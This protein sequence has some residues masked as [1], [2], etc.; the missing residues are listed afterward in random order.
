[1]ETSHFATFEESYD[2]LAAYSTQNGFGR[3]VEA[4]LVALLD[5]DG[6]FVVELVGFNERQKIVP[7]V[8][9]PLLQNL[10]VEAAGWAGDEDVEGAPVRTQF[11][12]EF[13]G[14]FHVGEGFAWNAEHE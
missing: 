3:C 1:M 12:G 11:F 14:C 5:G 6:G 2:A 8:E 9:E 13:V 10:I 4:A 7:S